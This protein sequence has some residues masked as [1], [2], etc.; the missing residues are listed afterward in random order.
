M[1]KQFLLDDTLKRELSRL[2]DDAGRHYHGMAH[3][4]ALLALAE[5]YRAFLADPEAVEAAI[6]FH[7]AVYDSR[8]K[9]NE[10]QSAALARAKLAGRTE[11]DRIERIAAMIEATATHTPPALGDKAAASDAAFMLDMDLA[12]LGAP[13]G[14]FAAYERGVRQE[15]AWVPEP[16]WLAGRGAVLKGFLARRQ[17]FHTQPF[18]G[19][20]E[21]QAR[22][23]L[24]VSLAALEKGPR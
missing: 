1:D 12:I 11:A 4:A 14:T 16:A 9:D 10:A 3:I 24:A 13:P 19:R 21:A 6:W 8:A 20:F 23:N 2:Y 5:E 15:Y 22:R 17:I 7:D 18:R